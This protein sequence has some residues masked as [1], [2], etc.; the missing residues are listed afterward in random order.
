M[1]SWWVITVLVVL[2]FIVI[3]FKELRHKFSFI[4]IVALLLF[5]VLS[6][7]KVYSEKKVDL[8]SLD[9]VVSAGKL[10]FS[11]LG[12]AFT[13]LKGISGYAVKQN[14]GIAENSANTNIT[15]T[16]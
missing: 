16:K 13:N 7:G 3:K 5:V 9:G 15:N 4:L 8:N 11:W 10:Y 12:N 14:W 2:I 6:F 1:L